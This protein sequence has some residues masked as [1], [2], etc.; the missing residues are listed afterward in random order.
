MTMANR[1]LKF[2]FVLALGAAAAGCAPAHFSANDMRGRMSGVGTIGIVSPDILVYEISGQGVALLE[3]R[4]EEASRDAVEAMMLFFKDTGFK[5]KVI[6]PDFKTR[7]EL[8]E[9]QGLSKAVHRSLQEFWNPAQ[10]M[11]PLTLGNLERLADFYTV[12]AFMFMDGLEVHKQETVPLSK[13]LAKLAVG[14]VYGTSALPKQGRSRATVSLADQGGGVIWAGFRDSEI[15]VE[16][17]FKD[18]EATGK[19]VRRLLSSFPR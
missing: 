9:V 18:R 11:P 7:V 15:S 6:G 5:V 1:L 3:K 4:S 19:L 10:V 16:E 2:V 14:A 8:R 13:S 17:N 12:E